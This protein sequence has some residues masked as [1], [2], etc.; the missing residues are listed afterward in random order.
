M[1]HCM[2]IPLFLYPCHTS[3]HAHLGCFYNLTIENNASIN[4]EVQ[5]SLPDPDVNSFGYKPRSR[6]AGSNIFR[7]STDFI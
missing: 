7:N 3:V 4:M 5:V 1:S 6:V 2:Y